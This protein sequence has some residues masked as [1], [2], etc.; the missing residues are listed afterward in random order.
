MPEDTD[1]AE[2]PPIVAMLEVK[3]TV[4][5][6]EYPLSVAVKVTDWPNVE[7]FK[8]EPTEVVDTALLTEKGAQLLLEEL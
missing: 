8:L 7:G 4:P 5:V 6:G 2:Q 3:A 1:T